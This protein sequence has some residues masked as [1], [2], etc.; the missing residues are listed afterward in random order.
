MRGYSPFMPLTHTGGT[1]RVPGL[2]PMP[3]VIQAPIF[4]TPPVVSG[5][6]RGA[7]PRGGLR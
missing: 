4:L 6:V 5:A 2:G 3:G 1:G 7:G